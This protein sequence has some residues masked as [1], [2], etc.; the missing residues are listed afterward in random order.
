MSLRKNWMI[1]IV[2][3]FGCFCLLMSWGIASQPNFMAD[4]AIRQGMLQTFLF[5]FI[6]GIV[7]IF[8]G[9]T[10]LKRRET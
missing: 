7:L 2:L 6:L 10:E 1:Y 5:Y 4:P 8:Y 9:Y 3:F